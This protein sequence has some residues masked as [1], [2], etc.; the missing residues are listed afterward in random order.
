[1]FEEEKITLDIPKEGVVVENGW[2]ITPDTYPGVSLLI[3][4]LRLGFTWW[5]DVYSNFFDN[6]CCNKVNLYSDHKVSGR[7]FG[8]WSPGAL[9]SVVCKVDWTAGAACGAG[10]QRGAVRSKRTL[11]LYLDSTSFT[12][13]TSNNSEYVFIIPM[14]QAFIC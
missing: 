12:A 3:I 9:L 7:P 14:T 1:M 10:T 11:Q 13:T 6:R 8:S 4:P 2:T 5:R